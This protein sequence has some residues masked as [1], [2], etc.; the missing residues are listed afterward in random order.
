MQHADGLALIIKY[1]PSLVRDGVNEILK[2]TH[3]A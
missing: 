2:R 3:N 1:D